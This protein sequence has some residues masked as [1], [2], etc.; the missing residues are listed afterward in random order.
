M[1]DKLQ[2]ARRKI[3]VL[4]RRIAALLARRWDLAVP[5]RALKK[6][7]TDR[8]RERQ[9]LANAAAAAGR[10]YAAGARAV[11]AGIIGQTKK[12]QSKK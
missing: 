12:L 3:D 8:E 6:R 2:A 10:R 4:D 1:R 5:L 7:A 11:F 9:V